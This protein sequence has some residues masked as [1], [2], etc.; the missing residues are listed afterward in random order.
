M[1]VVTGHN[2]NVAK[3][4]RRHRRHSFKRGAGSDNDT[5]LSDTM[6]IFIQTLQVTHSGS[7][8]ESHGISI[9]HTMYAVH[10]YCRITGC[11]SWSLVVDDL[12]DELVDEFVDDYQAVECARSLRETT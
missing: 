10:V 9:S 3:R 7:R 1:I 11:V 4:N 6:D 8:S 2:A 5:K 12:V